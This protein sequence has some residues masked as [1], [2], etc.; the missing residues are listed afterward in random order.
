MK[1]KDI[2]TCSI[3]GTAYT[4]IDDY[5]KCVESCVSNKKKEIEEE[6]NQKRLEEVNKALNAIKQAEKYYN[7]L[8][9]KFKADYPEEYKLNF[10]DHKC[11]CSCEKEDIAKTNSK[12]KPKYKT[13]ELSYERNSK[14]KPKM[15]AKVNGK[16]VDDDALQ[17][18]FDDPDAN[19]L[20]ADPDVNYIAKVLGIM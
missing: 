3:C 11:N 2:L 4:N 15:S 16:K 7:E 14:E 17:K 18:L 8:K 5:L 20:A 12:D 10:D 1:V 19:Y 13:M 6:R 9:D